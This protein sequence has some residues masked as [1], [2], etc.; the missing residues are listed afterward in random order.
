MPGEPVRMTFEVSPESRLLTIRLPTA[1]NVG[2]FPQWVR[3]IG[4]TPTREGVA[5]PIAQST[6]SSE[7]YWAETDM[8]VRGK[9][10]SN[11][12]ERP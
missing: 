4:E 9:C 10:K 3:S 11:R 2:K 7:I 8:N 6:D 1:L 5:D 12:M